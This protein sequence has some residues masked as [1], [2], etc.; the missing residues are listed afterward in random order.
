MSRLESVK[1]TSPGWSERLVDEVTDLVEKSGGRRIDVYT[2]SGKHPAHKA[3]REAA[4]RGVPVRLLT[5]ADPDPSQWGSAVVVERMSRSSV[6]PFQSLIWLGNQRCIYHAA[7]EL[8]FAA[9]DAEVLGI[10]ADMIEFLQRSNP[11]KIL[12]AIS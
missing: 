1:T 3:L 8:V 2:R 11:G 4:E 12:R 6:M 5:W 10:V 7:G 9:N